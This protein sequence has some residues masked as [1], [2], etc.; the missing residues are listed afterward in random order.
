MS[1][2]PPSKS[3]TELAFL[4]A[5]TTYTVEQA[6]ASALHDADELAEVMVFGL[7]K[8]GSF[9]MRSSRMTRRD[10]YWLAALAQEHARNGR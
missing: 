6:I 9:Y 7:Y 10:A 1:S 4:P 5:T 2:E 8:D 3:S